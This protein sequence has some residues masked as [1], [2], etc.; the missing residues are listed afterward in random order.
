MALVNCISR[1]A[2]VVASPTVP[3]VQINKL[4]AALPAPEWERWRQHLAPTAMLRGEVL[5]D[6][7]MPMPFVYFPTTAVVSL[8]YVTREG[9]STN[10]AV[11][12]NDGLVGISV[13]LGGDSAVS[14]AVVHCAGRG[15]RFPARMIKEEF[16][17]SE[18]VRHLLLPY[19]QAV[20]TQMAQA[21]ACNR[22]HS[23]E[24]QLCRLLLL[25]LDRSVDSE[26]SLTQESM[27]NMI[28]VRREGVTEA[29]VRLQNAGV[30]R[31]GRGHIAVIDRPALERRSCECYFV[32]KSECERL[33]L[34]S[35]RSGTP[36]VLQ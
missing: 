12:G 4:L 36:T 33:G 2:N 7:G 3:S 5:R 20:M 29:A 13:L 30:I 22:H 19:M 24:Q 9:E 11:V 34:Q 14:R 35:T 27:A 18:A 17:R 26:L 32:V 16:E 6:P 23:L 8:M 1:P 21:V 28:G 31:Y 25:N 15:Y 10:F